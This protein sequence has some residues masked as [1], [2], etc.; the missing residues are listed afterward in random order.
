[1]ANEK[2]EDNAAEIA[3]I[4]GSSGING[5]E[6]KKRRR[7]RR[8]DDMNGTERSSEGREHIPN[9]ETVVENDK[10]GRSKSNRKRKNKT[11][12][13]RSGDVIRSGGKGSILFTILLIGILFCVIDV[14]YIIGFVDRQL[15]ADIEHE[16]DLFSASRE[17]PAEQEKISTSHQPL[18]TSRLLSIAL[19]IL[20]LATF[21]F[22]IYFF[23]L[24]SKINTKE[25]LL[26]DSDIQ[27]VIPDND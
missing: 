7:R 6:Q 23:Y 2:S 21:G 1:M 3:P 17:E 5:E 26:P 19:R 27:Q 4:S 16:S 25:N 10:K 14:V 20:I 22:T 8:P 13:P 15:L 11:M 18:K 12:A 24:K 9:G